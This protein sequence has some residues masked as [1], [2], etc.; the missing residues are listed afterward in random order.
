MKPRR[1]A[2][3][4]ATDSLSPRFLSHLL[5][6][7]LASRFS[8][9]PLPSCLRCRTT[10]GRWWWWCSMLS[11]K[12][13]GA[14]WL[15]IGEQNPGEQDDRSTAPPVSPA[16]E[17]GGGPRECLVWVLVTSR[18]IKFLC[19][20]AIERSREGVMYRGCLEVC[21]CLREDSLCINRVRRKWK[22]F[23]FFCVFTLH[24]GHI[25]HS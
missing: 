23:T 22:A 10:N 1:H 16:D 3:P 6:L 21:V 14:V 8:L 12:K 19:L 5:S 13:G 20:Y 17:G 7:S 2:P 11:F 15:F 24:P 4:R 9:S 25:F 18:D